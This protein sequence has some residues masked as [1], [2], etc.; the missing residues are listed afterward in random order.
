MKSVITKI[1]T[2]LTESNG[3]TFSKWQ[4]FVLVIPLMAEHLFQG[5][6]HTV[7]SI[8][9]SDV[10]ENAISGMS[11]ASKV[12]EVFFALIGSVAVAS[13][14]IA[15]QYCGR[16]DYDR[17]SYTIKQSIVLSLL[18]SVPFSIIFSLSSEPL[19]NLLYAGGDKKVVEY[20]VRATR[21]KA[22]NCISSAV[23]VCLMKTF[24]CQGRSVLILVFNVVSNVFNVIGNYF[25]IYVFK[26]EVE[27]ASL[28]TVLAPLITCVFVVI[29]AAKKDNPVRLTSPG[30]LRPDAKEFKRLL[31]LGLP[32]GFE[33]T[34]SYFAKLMVSV[35]VVKCAVTQI[36]ANTVA[37]ELGA[38]FVRLGIGVGGA[39]MIVVGQCMGAGKKDE[40]KHYTKWL[41]ITSMFC[42]LVSALVIIVFMDPILAGYHL[43]ESTA[44]L[45]RELAIPYML[46]GIIFWTLSYT[47]P[48]ALRACGDVKYCMM[49][50]SVSLWGVRVALAFVIFYFIR[51]DIYA[52]WIASYADWAFRSVSNLIRFK[53]Q[54][55]LEKKVI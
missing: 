32:T 15:T 11:L 23:L 34:L 18:I 48:H 16:K 3:R 8:M 33:N 52:V 20:A 40:V 1:K 50:S 14:I 41:I 37:Q 30:G 47:A 27:G 21:V 26:W 53:S 2:F 55:W 36:N 13:A 43:T 9:V 6:M 51:R 7:D 12:N 4:L 25:F 42:Q 28:S 35:I 5:L 54:K 29:A 31:A 10:S 49:L 17:A 45:T 22:F 46:A 44:A 24:V 38:L 39:L 19:L